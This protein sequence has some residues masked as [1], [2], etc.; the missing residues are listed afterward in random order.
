[1]I[2]EKRPDMTEEE[3]LWMVGQL[4]D[5][6]EIPNWKSVN[7]QVNRELGIDEDKWRDESSFRK[8]YAAAKRFK[9]NCFDRLKDKEDFFQLQEVRDTIYKEKKKLF[10]QRREYNKLLTKDARFEHLMDHLVNVANN[11]NTTLP[12]VSNDKKYVVNKDREG[13]VCFSDWHYGMKT[14]NIWNFYN[15]DVCKERVKKTVD[16]II[17]YIVDHKI[18]RVS[19]VLLGDFAHGACHVTARIK[20]DEDVCD[21]L[22]HVSEILAEAIQEISEYVNQVRV[23]SCYGNHM[24]TVQNKKESINSDNM[25]KVIPWWLRERFL[26]NDKVTVVDSVYREFTMLNILGNHICCVHGNDKNFKDIGVIVNNIFTKKYGTSIDYTISGDKHHLEEFEQYG[27]E[28]ILVRSLCG[29]D[30][31]AS[32]RSLFSKPGQTFMVFNKQGRECTYNIPLDN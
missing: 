25:E 29:T 15:T 1:M 7:D 19:V 21:Q 17:E 30:D 23:Y 8:R 28:S 11:I 27:I 3:F 32:D 4:I 26:F 5:S 14:D 22:M 31:Y 6:G 9:E 2:L 18:D 12:L 16:Y 20:S 13:L 10:D 24:R